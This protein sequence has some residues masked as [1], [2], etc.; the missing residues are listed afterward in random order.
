LVLPRRTRRI[1]PDAGGDGGAFALA[2]QLR[3]FV[4]SEWPDVLVGPVA[5][6]SEHAADETGAASR[7]TTHAT[8]QP[9]R[10]KRWPAHRRF[11]DGQAARDER[12]VRKL[13]CA[14]IRVH[15]VLMVLAAPAQMR[16]PRIR[17]PKQLSPS[18]SA[19]RKA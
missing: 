16:S 15:D 3:S 19:L 1:W 7:A 17:L 14:R 10:V 4:Q 5:T 18:S 11:D 12:A 13:A 6:R 8:A 2:R 9:A